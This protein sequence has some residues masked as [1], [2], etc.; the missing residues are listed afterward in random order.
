MKKIIGIVLFSLI[1][2]VAFPQEKAV[3]NWNVEDND[4]FYD[5]PCPIGGGFVEIPVTG[6]IG[7]R[8]EITLPDGTSFKKNLLQGITFKNLPEGLTGDILKIS[9]SKLQFTL[10][11]KVPALSATHQIGIKISHKAVNGEIETNSLKFLDIPIQTNDIPGNFTSPVTGRKYLLVFN[12]EFNGKAINKDR[13]MFRR[14][15]GTTCTR[16]LEYQGQTCLVLVEDE[17]SILDGDEL[18]LGVYQ[19]RKGSRE[20]F[21]GGIGTA[22]NF[23]PQYGYFETASSM[24]DCSGDGYFPAFWVQ[25]LRKDKYTTGTELDIME[26][27]SKHKKIYQ[28]VHWFNDTINPLKHDS[29]SENF[30]L[31]DK[32]KNHVY[33]LEWTPEE[34]IFYMDGKVTRRLYKKDNPRMVPSAYQ[35]VYFS[36][37][38]STWG[39]DV[40]AEDNQ[41]PAYSSFD[42]CRVLQQEE[43][44]AFYFYNGKKQ[45]VKAKDRIGKY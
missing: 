26:Y 22:E 36:M 38:A 10:S 45:L 3:W 7:G 25:Y 13:W 9:A 11:G 24:R 15:R 12:D 30:V 42:Y 40:F 2:H 14:E 44:E 20:V 8:L 43:Q 31:E 5:I 34:L 23:L 17:A 27:N 33:G 37:S 29:S 39:G 28:T 6:K 1:C 19:K 32:D 18:R 35:M 16:T 21:T 4:P 41:L